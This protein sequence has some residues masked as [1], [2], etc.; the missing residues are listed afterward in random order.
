MQEPSVAAELGRRSLACRLDLTMAYLR[1]VHFVVYYGG[2]EFADEGDL[3]FSAVRACLR[4]G[5]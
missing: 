3:L 1:R 2:D 5:W 4:G